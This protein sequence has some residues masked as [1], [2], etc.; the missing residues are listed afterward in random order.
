MEDAPENVGLD[1]SVQEITAL[2]GEWYHAIIREF[3]FDPGARENWEVL[4]ME[5]ANAL[6]QFRA[7]EPGDEHEG[8]IF[9]PKIAEEKLSALIDVDSFLKE[10]CLALTPASRSAFLQGAGRAWLKAAIR[11]GRHANGEFGADQPR[12][13]RGVANDRS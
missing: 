13:V 1:L 11:L 12:A 2:S 4:A 3:V 9:S 5:L 8:A 7:E 10:R 6:A